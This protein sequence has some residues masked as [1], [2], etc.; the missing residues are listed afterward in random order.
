MNSVESANLL[1]ILASFWKDKNLDISVLEDVV[2]QNIPLL[3]DGIKSLIELNSINLP[4]SAKVF[5]SVIQY[6]LSNA[7][8]NQSLFCFF[9]F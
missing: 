7:K 9:S 5:L 8:P 2:L 6:F 1:W 4:F 3:A